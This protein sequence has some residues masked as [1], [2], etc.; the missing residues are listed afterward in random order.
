MDFFS[1][2]QVSSSMSDSSQP[3]GS[4][5]WTVL[6]SGIPPQGPMKRRLGLDEAENFNVPQPTGCGSKE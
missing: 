1:P 2:T 6:G 4:V 3:V 5:G